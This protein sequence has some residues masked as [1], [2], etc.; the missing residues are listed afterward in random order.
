VNQVL[1]LGLPPPTGGGAGFDPLTLAPFGFWLPDPLFLFEEED[2]TGAITANDAVGYL[3]DQ[4]G[5]ALPATQA[6]AASRPLYKTAGG[7]HWLEGDG[8]DDVLATAAFGA[9]LAQ[10]YCAVTAFRNL[11]EQAGAN[12]HIASGTGFNG[13][14]YITDTAEE[15]RSFAGAELESGI[16]AAV[17]TDVVVVQ[18]FNGA[19]SEIAID[20]G[21]AVTGAAGANAMADFTLFAAGVAQPSNARF[22]GRILF[23]YIPTDPEIAQLITYFAARQGRVL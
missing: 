20:A 19:S 2:G 13:A 5:S 16:S 21:A 11:R 22:Y 18:I 9:G 12:A 4:S 7:L 23:D 6:T 17:G 1:G 14:L 10:P 15:I 3:A 8:I